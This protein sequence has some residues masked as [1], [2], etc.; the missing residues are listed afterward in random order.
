MSGQDILEFLQTEEGVKA[1][2]EVAYKEDGSPRFFI[3]D[4]RSGSIK[5]LEAQMEMLF[6]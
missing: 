5:D 1:Q 2:N 3:I 4:D 6:S